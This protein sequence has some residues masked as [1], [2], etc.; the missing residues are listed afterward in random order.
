MEYWKYIDGYDNLYMISNH[1]RV[2]SFKNK[3]YPF[4]KL[5]SPYLN[6]RGYLVVTL[7]H[8]NHQKHHKIHRLVAIYFIENPDNLPQVNHIDANPLNNHYS[9]LEWCTQ[10]YNNNYRFKI[11][12]MSN[13]GERNPSTNLKNE[14]VLEIYNKT[15]TTNLKDQ[16]IAIEY[17]INK[18]V[19]NSIRHGRR[20]NSVTHHKPIQLFKKSKNITQGEY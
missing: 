1:G 6:H 4:G 19:V 11:G 12:T 15:Q 10:R 9:N 8:N 3:K 13:K 18:S 14:Q 7:K 2:L 5:I 20:F 17:N 16:E